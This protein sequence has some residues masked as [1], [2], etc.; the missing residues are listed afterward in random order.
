MNFKGSKRIASIG[1]PP[2]NTEAKIADISDP[3]GKGLPANQQGELL[4]RGP[5]VM[6]GYL[7]N[8]KATDDMLVD[9]WLHTGDMAYYDEDGYFYI[10]DRLKELIKVKG[11]QVAPAEL[12]EILR[13]HPSVA[14]AAVIGVND[15]ATGELPRAF[16]VKK[17][18]VDVNEQELQDFVAQ[19]V[20]PYKQIKGGVQFLDSIP[21]NTTGKIL[22]RELKLKY[23]S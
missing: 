11:F 10:T 17:K 7:N 23:C 12:E 6:L 16:I 8:K 9:G 18:D 20:A 13:D 22:R 21:K 5:Q 15:A 1:F 19:K 14:D 3:T 4:I 2:S